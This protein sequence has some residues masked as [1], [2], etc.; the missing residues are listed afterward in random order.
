M[1]N[2]F[3]NFFN[4]FTNLNFFFLPEDPDTVNKQYH[5]TTLAGT[6]EI[7][8]ETKRKSR[9]VHSKTQISTKQYTCLATVAITNIETLFEGL[10]QKDSTPD[11]NIAGIPYCL[12][13]E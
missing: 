3:K 11:L 1:T 13:N 5:F 8:Q 6:S 10:N 12:L 9:Q 7:Y 4:G 2:L